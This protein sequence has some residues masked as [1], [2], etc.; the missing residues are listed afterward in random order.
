MYTAKEL[1][2]MKPVSKE[3][4]EKILI[5][6]KKHLPKMGYG[7]GLSYVRD[8]QDLGRRSGWTDFDMNDFYN[9]LEVDLC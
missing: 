9:S 1:R 8:V 2:Q 5:D 3:D 6:T 4:M 7:I